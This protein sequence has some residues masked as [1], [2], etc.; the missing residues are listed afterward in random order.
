M[1][2]AEEQP[3]RLYKSRSD[4][5]LNMSEHRA[6]MREAKMR[7]LQLKELRS[8]KLAGS[9][10]PV[11]GRRNDYHSNGAGA[12]KEESP[13]RTLNRQCSPSKE[14]VNRI[15]VNVAQMSRE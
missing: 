13:S 10:S 7:E 6:R 4:E 5:S 1:F 12:T 2:P 8:Q 11:Q 14:A 15:P 3:G 9:E